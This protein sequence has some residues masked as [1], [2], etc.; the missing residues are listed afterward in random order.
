MP[1]MLHPTASQCSSHEVQAKCQHQV[2]NQGTLRAAS[3]H[4][5]L[6]CLIPFLLW[7]LEDLLE[8]ILMLRRRRVCMGEQGPREAD[9]ALSF[10]LWS[11]SHGSG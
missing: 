11:H 9:E 8:R 3:S 5:F 7:A 10:C 2:L 4:L 6:L 1:P